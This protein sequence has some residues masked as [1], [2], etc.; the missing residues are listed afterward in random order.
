[1]DRR[2]F[3]K[4]VVLTS[5]L[6]PFVLAGSKKE[7]E[8]QLYLISDEPEKYLPLLLEKTN[9]YSLFSSK[10]LAFL[11]HHRRAERLLSDF[12]EKGWR[13]EKSHYSVGIRLFNLTT[14]SFSSFALIKKGKIIDLRHQELRELWR[15]MARHSSSLLTVATF[16]M[17]QIKVQP[18][19]KV[20]V[21]IGGQLVDRFPIT[22]NREK[23]YQTRL[24]E[25]VIAIKNRDLSVIDSSCRH[26]ICLST[27][28]IGFSGERIICAPNNFMVEIQGNSP[29][30][31]TIIG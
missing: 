7:G 19:K 1:M 10:S 15:Q 31:D 23:R 17:N 21:W 14:P 3:L 30:F 6:S 29:L 18:G 26:K 16:P 28:P 22:I 8:Q 20:R 11:N 12:R 25:V 24:G 27:P 13:E 2:K 5:T 9:I 4:S